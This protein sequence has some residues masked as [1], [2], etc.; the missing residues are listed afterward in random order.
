MQCCKL[1]YKAKTQFKQINTTKTDA[2]FSLST[3]AT[4]Q[5]HFIHL[6]FKVKFKEQIVEGLD[7]TIIEFHLYFSSGNYTGDF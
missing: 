6:S 5:A 7:F 4:T 1:L 2:F 3:D